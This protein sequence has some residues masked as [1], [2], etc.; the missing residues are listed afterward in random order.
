[1]EEKGYV[2]RCNTYIGS[3]AQGDGEKMYDAYEQPQG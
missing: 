2:I 1:M 3:R